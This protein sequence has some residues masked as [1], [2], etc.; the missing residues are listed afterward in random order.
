MVMQPQAIYNCLLEVLVDDTLL[1]VF[2]IM[3]TYIHIYIH[4]Y[5]HAKT[6][7]L[8]NTNFAYSILSF[9]EI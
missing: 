3:L 7:L 8:T 5:S 4:T 2:I 6:R 1:Q 9:S